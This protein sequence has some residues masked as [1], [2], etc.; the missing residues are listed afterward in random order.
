MNFFSFLFTQDGALVAL[1][2][3]SSPTSRAGGIS[4]EGTI[5]G[6]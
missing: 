2:V 4:P 1:A 6:L 5:A 3:P